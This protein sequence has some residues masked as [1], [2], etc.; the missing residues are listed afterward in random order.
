MLRAQTAINRDLNAEITD[1]QRTREGDASSLRRRAADFE[2][3]AE[4]RQQRLQAVEAQYRAL[5]RRVHAM[6][7][8]TRGRSGGERGGEEGG[9]DEEEE[10]ERDVLGASLSLLGEGV[11]PGQNVLEVWVREARL[12]PT[13]VDR[14]ASTFAM[15]D[16]MDFETQATP[17]LAGLAPQFNFSTTYEVET[18]A[19]FVRHLATDS[20]TVE[21]YRADGAE[22]R[23]LAQC[24]VPLR[25]LLSPDS[26]GRVRLDDAP[27]LSPHDGGP[28]GTVALE[29]RL[30]LPVDEL[31]EAYLQQYPG[32]RETMRRAQREDGAGA[33][34][35]RPLTGSHNHLL[36]SVPY[37]TGLLSRHGGDPSPSLYFRLPRQPYALSA[38]V[39]ASSSPQFD[40]H[41]AFPLPVDEDS[42]RPAAAARHRSLTRPTRPA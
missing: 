30:A 41:Q 33:V 34:G 42:V 25:G 7:R 9:E 22:H 17:I 40:W 8:A 28:V 38:V 23:L 37:A 18:D 4:R 27:A 2:A 29:L 13:R 24:P 31:L 32:E 3:L 5:L 10:E 16:F 39:P 6:K 19:F 11:A 20:V 1:A 15:V 36:I 12:D 21:L 35:R 14:R 26:G